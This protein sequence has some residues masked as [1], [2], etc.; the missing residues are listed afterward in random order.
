M[1]DKQAVARYVADAVTPP[2]GFRCRSIRAVDARM[3]VPVSL[4]IACESSPPSKSA[5]KFTSRRN[6]IAILQRLARATS[7]RGERE[8][9]TDAAACLREKL[10]SRRPSPPLES[11]VSQFAEKAD[12]ALGRDAGKLTTIREMSLISISLSA[13]QMPSKF[14][15]TVHEW[16]PEHRYRSYSKLFP[17]ML[18]E[19]S[20][21]RG[22]T[23]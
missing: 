21:L 9:R 18:L 6:A 5:R 4:N 19:I 22:I 15:L 2:S 7:A 14:L 10:S 23:E 16:Q 3:C 12:T 8:R 20:D 13:P 17:R 1:R 11:F